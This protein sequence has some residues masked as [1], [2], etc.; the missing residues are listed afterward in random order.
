[1]VEPE[2]RHAIS[3]LQQQI[4]KLAQAEQRRQLDEQ[5]QKMQEVEIRTI[6]TLF[7]KAATYTN[8]F[9]IGGY[10]AFWGLWTAT[11][12]YLMPFQ[13]ILSALLM[14]ASVATF[15]FFEVY[16]QHCT[17]MANI[18]RL[19]VLRTPEN[20]SSPEKYLQA[21]KE[22]QSD[23]ER[24]NVQFVRVWA[25]TFYITVGAALAAVAVLGTAFVYRLTS[26]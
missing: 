21:L 19:R 26:G 7:D 11:K 2:T 18:K 16:K 3:S 6:S 9:V 1:M 4:G 10:A 24:T 17:S 20:Q 22:F 14:L 13:V 25:V 5:V 8:V 15:V 12:Q 23:G